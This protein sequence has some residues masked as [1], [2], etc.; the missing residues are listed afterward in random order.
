M[1]TERIWPQ[2]HICIYAK[3]AV[4]KDE[5]SKETRVRKQKR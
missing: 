1:P 4:R 2:I 3:K 5:L